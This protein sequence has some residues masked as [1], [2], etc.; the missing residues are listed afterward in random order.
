MPELAENVKNELLTTMAEAIRTGDTKSFFEAQVKLGGEIAQNLLEEHKA[1][2]SRLVEGTVIELDGLT[3]EERAYY[4]EVKEVGFDEAQ[5][6][7]PATI[8]ER[9]FE[10][11]HR[12]HKL[13]KA[14]DFN[15]TT[16]LTEFICRDET[17]DG[18]SAVW[19]PL[20]S[21]IVKKL[22]GAFKLVKLG[23][24][25][26]TAYLPIHQDMLK[27]GPKYLDKYIIALLKESIAI[28]LE[29]AIIAGDGK[30]K[31]IGML[32]DLGQPVSDG[33]YSE[34][35][36]VKLNS[37]TPTD[38]GNKIMAPLTK[39]GKR[40]VEKVLMVVNPLDY[41][42]KIFPV[43]TFLTADK[44]YVHGVLPIPADIV[45]SPAAPKGKMPVGV[46]KDYFLGISTNQKIQHS[47][48][49]KFLEDKRIYKTKI[50][51]DGSPK[52]NDSFLVFD[53]SELAPQA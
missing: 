33:R 44:T 4:N 39:D 24:N 26:L 45:Q 41:W 15:N 6:L 28:G 1:E 27:L 8:F 46:G 18:Q 17:K 30:D 23:A 53:I 11:I 25:S 48:E 49:Y 21:E 42:Q 13:L 37:F 52:D 32:M 43:S 50:T 47:D 9:V 7:M 10:G 40:T 34:K 20:N 22:E 12:E 19:G 2:Q 16:G 3:A 31:P 36:A 35:T 5:T 51:A 38:L 14:I 29:V